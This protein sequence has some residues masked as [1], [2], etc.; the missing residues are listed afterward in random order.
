MAQNARQIAQ[1]LERRIKMLIFVRGYVARHVNAPS[2]REIQ[3]A[4]GYSSS[5]MVQADVRWWIQRGDLVRTGPQGRARSFTTQ[6]ALRL[7]RG[8]FGEPA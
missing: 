5:S 1:Q 6:E 7:I 3:E 2:V 4:L 8:A